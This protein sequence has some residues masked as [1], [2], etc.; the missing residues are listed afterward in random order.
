MSTFF[1][2]RRVPAQIEALLRTHVDRV[3]DA[4]VPVGSRD[5]VELG[6]LG[7]SL[8]GAVGVL[9]LGTRQ[10]LGRPTLDV[11]LEFPADVVVAVEDGLS[12]LADEA[13]LTPRVDLVGRLRHQVADEV[14]RGLHQR[15]GQPEGQRGKYQVLHNASRCLYSVDVRESTP[16]LWFG[17]FRC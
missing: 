3:D 7:V 6:R 2:L 10:Q 14:L 8:H 13:L 16:K 12:R 1:R 5:L 15:G 17:V 9:V 4:G 11:P